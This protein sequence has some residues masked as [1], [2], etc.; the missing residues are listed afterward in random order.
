MKEKTFNN[1]S[2][3]FNILSDEEKQKLNEKREYEA[4][5]LTT[6]ELWVREENRTK[7]KTV[8]II[9]GFTCSENIIEEFSH[10]IKQHLAVGGTIKDGQLILQG[11]MAEKVIE[12]LKNSGYKVKKK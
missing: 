6:D 9:E 12:Y 1:F 2:D 8:T 4:S 5:L 11:K 7:G 10:Q 3:L